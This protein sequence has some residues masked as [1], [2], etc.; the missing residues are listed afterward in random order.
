MFDHTGLPPTSPGLRGAGP[1][2]PRPALRPSLP[3]G[4]CLP[5]VLLP[6]LLLWK[7]PP[8]QGPPSPQRSQ[9][10][11]NPS[12]PFK[13]THNLYVAK[14]T[15][16]VSVQLLRNHLTA[17]HA[18][19]HAHLLGRFFLVSMITSSLPATSVTTPSQSLPSFIHLLVHSFTFFIQQI[20]TKSP[21]LANPYARQWAVRRAK[22]VRG[23][24]ILGQVFCVDFPPL[25]RLTSGTPAFSVLSIS[26]L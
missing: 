5:A 20:F 18:V 1:S 19:D 15:G 7:K 10:L 21:L 3:C 4:L 16:H 25:L 23:V 8:S 17:F 13:V 6:F 2:P 14:F 24:Y 22:P 12:T 26:W 11:A 9:D